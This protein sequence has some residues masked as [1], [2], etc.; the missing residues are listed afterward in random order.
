[1]FFV[2]HES[3]G[4]FNRDSAYSGLLQ[5]DVNRLCILVCKIRATINLG[6]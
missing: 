3:V 5:K 1:V 6:I 4:V 2:T